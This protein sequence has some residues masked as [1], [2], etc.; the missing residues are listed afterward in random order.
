MRLGH[1]L[2]AAMLVSIPLTAAVELPQ[3][4]PKAS[5]A[6]RIGVTDLKI[7]YHSPAMKGREIFGGLV[8]YGEVWRLGA[9]NA[10]TLETSTTVRL[11]GAEIPAG[12][13][14]LF[15]IP[16]KDEWTFIV[17]S[18]AQQW[19][20]YFYDAKKDVA[21]FRASPSPS[22]VDEWMS[23]EIVPRS[24]AA[25]TIV[26]EWADLEIPIALEVDTPKIVWSR[27]EQTLAGSPT[28]EDWHQAARYALDRNERTDDA[29]GWIDKALAEDNFWNYEVKAR[30]L[31]AKG[32]T[33]E[34]IPLLEKAASA[35]KGTAP[36]EYIEG[37]M[38]TIR[39][40]T[41]AD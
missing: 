21:R 18:N 10:T 4:S 38:K 9:N 19:G 37:L 26:F 33:A 39:E 30:L 36:D 12:K 6:R 23:F 17:N 7:D 27:I 34:A 40:W 11:N 29:L 16:G 24:D 5:I 8:P 22:D 1:A 32:K 20:A 28:W 2:M 13:Y 15:A 25:G 31:H 14:A 35:A 41:S 3:V